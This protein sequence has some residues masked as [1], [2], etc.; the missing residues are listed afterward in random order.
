MHDVPH[1]AWVQQATKG[2]GEAV[3]KLLELHLPALLAYVRLHAGDVVRPRE[4][5]ADVV[6]SVCRD[7]LEELGSFEYRGIA[8]FRKWLFLKVRLK[9]V[10]HQRH[11]LAARRNVQREVRA[12]TC[13]ASASRIEALYSALLTPSSAAVSR[14][15]IERFEAA[16]AELPADYQQVI[17]LSRVFGMSQREVAEEMKRSPQAIGALLHRALSRLG[18]RLYE[19]RLPE[20]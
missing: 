8:A 5:C 15:K 10:D 16:F 17:T 2:D 14:E 1:E 13:F 3:R 12:T 9:L 18:R 6:Q 11:H 7:V 20:R 4:S 19:T